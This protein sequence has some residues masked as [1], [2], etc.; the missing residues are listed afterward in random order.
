[1]VGLSVGRH[2]RVE[3]I[4]R[5]HVRSAGDEA[6]HALE[7]DELIEDGSTP[8]KLALLESPF[9]TIAMQSHRDELLNPLTEER[10]ESLAALLEIMRVEEVVGAEL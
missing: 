9:R 6:L 7:S 1:M 8:A 4:R 3:V 5:H 2:L 10:P